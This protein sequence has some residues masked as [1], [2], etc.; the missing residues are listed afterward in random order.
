MNMRNAYRL[1]VLA[2]L[3]QLLPRVVSAQMPWDSPQ[4]LGPGSPAGASFVA[5]HYGLDPYSGLGALLILRTG[6]APDGFGIRVSGAQG[7]GDK[8]NVAGGID[9][10]HA[11]SKSSAQFPLDLMLTYGA[12]ASYGEFVEFAVPVGLAGGRVYRSEKTWF[13]PYTS[14][15]AIVEGRAGRARPNSDITLALAIDVGADLTLGRSFT[16]RTAASFGDRQ[17]IALGLHVGGS[18][19]VASAHAAPVR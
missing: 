15:R 4:M 19:R 1:V 9:F 5:V 17:A 3:V 10:T 2:T 8:I 13:R 18:G 7:L 6:T 16:L 12:G 11:I 14:A